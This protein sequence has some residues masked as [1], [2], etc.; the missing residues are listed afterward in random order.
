MIKLRIN[1]KLMRA[2]TM[3]LLMLLTT[4]TAWALETYTVTF[5][6]AD[7]TVLSS[8]EYYYGTAAADI[9]KPA[10]PTK[11]ADA[12]YTYTFSG[13]SPAIAEVTGDA[14]YTATYS[15]TVNKYTVV[16]ENADGTELSSAEYDYGTD[17]DDIVKPADP[18]KAA[19]A[20]YTYT[21]NGWSPAIASVTGNA[22]YTA[23]YSSTV[24]K[25]TVVFKDEDGTQLSSAE[26]DYGTAAA[27]IVKPADPTKAATAQYTYTFSGWSPE[28]AD[29]TGDATYTA[30]YSQTENPVVAYI[31]AIGNV[32]DDLTGSTE[33]TDDDGVQAI[34]LTGTETTLGIANTDTWYVVMNSN[35]DESVDGGLDLKYER[36]ISST[37]QLLGNVHLILADGAT[38]EVVNLSAEGSAIYASSATLT[39]YGQGGQ[40]EG[41]LTVRAFGRGIFQGSDDFKGTTTINGGQVTIVGTD[42]GGIVYGPTQ[43][44]AGGDVIIN[45]GTVNINGATNFAIS[46]DNVTIN[47]GTVKAN[48]DNSTLGNGIS[49]QHVTINGGQVEAIGIL[50]GIYSNYG[51]ITLGWT[52]PTDYI[53][54]NTYC[55][56]VNQAV[57]TADGQRFVAYNM[58]DESDI[59]ATAI[60]SGTVYD[61]STLAGKTLKP[62]DGLFISAPAEVNV[63]LPGSNQ[64]ATADFSIASTPYYI[65]KGEG[66]TVGLDKTDAG[67]IA[68]DQS[69]LWNLTGA[70]LDTYDYIG[71][72]GAL[73]NTDNHLAS[74][75]LGTQDVT[76]AIDFNPFSMPGGY[77][78]KSTV[79]DGKNVTWSLT[80]NGTDSNDKVTYKLSIA[81]NANEGQTDYDMADYTSADAPW[82]DL[83]YNAILVADEAAYNAYKASLSDADKAKLHSN[84]LTLFGQGATHTWATFCAA[85]HYLMPDNCTAYAV[86]SISNGTAMVEEV[87]TTSNANVPYYGKQVVPAFA[88]VLVKRTS[89]VPTDGFKATFAGVE[90]FRNPGGW[91]NGENENKCIDPDNNLYIFNKAYGYNKTIGYCWS[92]A[93][94]DDRL[95]G[96]MGIANE[97]SA[98]T[99]LIDTNVDDYTYFALYNNQFIRIEGDPGIQPHRAILKVN[100]GHLTSGSQQAPVLTIGT[101]TTSLSPVPSPK[102]EGREYFYTLDGRRLEG[103][104]TQ[105]GIYIVNGKKRVV[106]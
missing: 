34:P 19:T 29:V 18:T 3:L 83:T 61:V 46:V 10:D 28:I 9:V 68:D 50:Y 65:Y 91:D 84:L 57:K 63:T 31:D 39:V 59:S 42:N 95:L 104:P 6:D 43:G 49:A 8:A 88:P 98:I 51:D 55:V 53:K 35:T 41:A 40:T 37:I 13:W 93:E 60:V 77:C 105:K 97:G 89:D 52:K 23:T 85:D 21:F 25:Y 47:S 32:H 92:E 22:T 7:G 100:N 36:A 1:T 76:V 66:G 33:S 11:A 86:M 26:Y 12:Q 64:A 106:K 102:G 5:V 54:A 101:E 94:E 69:V 30:T 90:D 73:Q 80:E 82:K 81:K 48:V 20:Q 44:I 62:L 2:A 14:T 27:D 67:M 71:T 87:P 17:A 16:F 72:N 75:T 103:K 38:M 74:F 58:A 4:T 24:N 79:N 99:G 45:G 15:S 56:D 96:N 70:T 78:G